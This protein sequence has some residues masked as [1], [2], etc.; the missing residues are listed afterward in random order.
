MG[1]INGFIDATFML[2]ENIIQAEYGGASDQVQNGKK[3]LNSY[4]NIYFRLSMMKESMLRSCSGMARKHFLQKCGHHD[5]PQS[6]LCIY[7]VV[8]TYTRVYIT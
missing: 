3:I 6:N 2:V 8:M 5:S 7:Y 4:K 1:K